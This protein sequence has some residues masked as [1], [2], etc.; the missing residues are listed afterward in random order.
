MK[1][2]GSVR[3]GDIKTMEIAEHDT[4]YGTAYVGHELRINDKT[5]G[6]VRMGTGISLDEKAIVFLNSLFNDMALKGLLEKQVGS[7]AWQ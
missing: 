3:F 6:Y 5:V 4:C 1:V 2:K 7:Y